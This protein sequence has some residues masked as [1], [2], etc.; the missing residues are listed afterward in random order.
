MAYTVTTLS[1][2]WIAY[3]QGYSNLGLEGELR[4]AIKWATDYLLKVKNLSQLPQ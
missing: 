2:G 3:R 1:W 4:A